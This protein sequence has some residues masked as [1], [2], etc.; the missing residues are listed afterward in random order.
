MPKPQAFVWNSPEQR[1]LGRP[2][3]CRESGCSWLVVEMS[4]FADLEPE[5]ICDLTEV[6]EAGSGVSVRFVALDLLF[7]YPKFL[8]KLPLSPA[9][10]HACL[11]E[12]GRD[13]GERVGGERGDAAGFELFVGAD[14]LS[15]VI[16]L[17]LGGVDLELVQFLVD[18]RRRSC[19]RA[20]Q[21]LSGTGSRGSG[22][23]DTGR[24]W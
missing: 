4:G 1:G 23:S 13:I 11:D 5:R 2:D 21:R 12:Q 3:G 17:S 7:G 15:E 14:L 20:R 22:C 19:V 9:A 18:R 24:R 8:G 16:G 10:H 6:D